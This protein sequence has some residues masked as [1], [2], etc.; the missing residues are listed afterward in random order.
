M[1]G[2]EVSIAVLKHMFVR[3]NAIVVGH[4][5]AV[6]AH[7]LAIWQVGISLGA[8]FWQRRSF[9][10]EIHDVDILSVE[11]CRVDL[12]IPKDA[13]SLVQSSHI[14]TANPATTILWLDARI[15]PSILFG[16]SHHICDTHVSF[17]CNFGDLADVLAINAQS[18]VQGFAEKVV[19]EC[20]H[21]VFDHFE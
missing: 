9:I 17:S 11:L 21:D 2:R 14:G 8:D 5:D 19:S 3:L 15:N 10:K 13:C 7:K 6:F 16:H 1:V 4:F 20:R 18:L 12:E